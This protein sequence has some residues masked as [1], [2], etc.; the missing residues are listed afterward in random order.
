MVKLWRNISPAMAALVDLKTYVSVVDVEDEVDVDDEVDVVVEVDDD[1]E[2]DVDEE[3]VMLAVFE[4][5]MLGLLEMPGP[6]PAE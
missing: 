4:T 6:A 3:L 2:L 5:G 1:E